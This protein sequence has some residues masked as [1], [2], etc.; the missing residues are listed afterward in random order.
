MKHAV[1]QQQIVEASRKI[2]TQKG[3][4]ELTMRELARSLKFTEAAIYKH[5][6]SKNEVIGLMIE[7]IE[8]TLMETI[9]AAAA[10]SGK[11]TEKLRSV[12]TSHLSYAEKRKGV[13]F[14]VINETIN[15]KDKGLQKRM[16]RVL[17]AYHN[18]IGD[19]VAEGIRSGEFQKSVDP[20]SASVAFFGMVQSLAT[21][22]ALNGYR[23]DILK[24]HV[25][26]MFDLYINGLSAK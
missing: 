1:R 6:R 4:S 9:D 22:W 16:L 20:S 8:R 15:L 14:A 5:F 24:A 21:L 19:L 26:A 18:R 3:M 12:F 2:I 23:A 17:D 10:G 11:A 13:S 7:D 25:P